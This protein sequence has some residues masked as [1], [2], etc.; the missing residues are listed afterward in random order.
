MR[1]SRSSHRLGRLTAAVCVS[2]ASLALLTNSLHAQGRAREKRI[3]TDE[4]F[5]SSVLP[6][7]QKYCIECH[8][9][10]EA[11]GDVSF[12]DF[13]RAE[14]V[15]E[16]RGTWE[17]AFKHLGVDGMP[18]KD[19]DERPTP[20]ERRKLVEWLELKLYHVDPDLVDD[21]GRVTIQ[22]LNRA[23]YNNTVRD[24][25]GVDIQAAKDFPADDVGYGFSNIGD[26]LS[27]PPLLL[28]KYVAAAEKI[29]TAAISTD[30][31]EARRRILLARPSEKKTAQQAARE[32]FAA[33]MP[34][35]F[36]RPVDD[37]E[38]DRVVALVKLADTRGDSFE[39]GIQAGLQAILISPHFLFRIEYDAQPN[40]PQAEHH[41]SDFE[42]AARLSYFL[43]ST[44]PDEEL[45]RLAKANKLHERAVLDKQIARMLK[46]PKAGALV[47]NFASQW[48][49]L[50]ALAE[51]TP[52]PKL[53][54][55]FSPQLRADMLRETEMFCAAIFREDRSLLDFLDADFTFLNERL[56]KHY[57][58]AGVKGEKFRRVSLAGT[59]RAGVMTHASIL[60]LTSNP[61]RTSLVKRGNWI[62]NNIM[63]LLLP[64]PPGNV[65]SLEEGAKKSGA[66]T[67]RDQ[68]K[69]HRESAAC[70]SCHETL[71]PLGFGFENFDAI[72]R[73]RDKAEGRPVESGGVLP[74]GDAFGGPLELVKVLKQRKRKFA[75]L[76]TKKMFTYALG[77]GLELPDSVA[78]DDVVWNL[79]N[80]DY[81]FSVLVRGI[82]HSRP[83]LMRRGDET[84]KQTGSAK[85]TK[86]AKKDEGAKK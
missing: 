41:L 65:P 68:L 81:R 82:V 57:S 7:V 11:E 77:R 23:E 13:R 33:L 60:T 30:S 45:F 73:W 50:G 84:A 38:V 56:A 64:E 24:L 79:E 18:P 27:L 36:R 47:K 8:G 43:W 15:L 54:P 51:V 69:L 34:R 53:F 61:D 29:A 40:N 42:L 49:N 70:A 59:K 55:S 14:Q 74:P 25:L 17:K 20:A 52:D 32:I 6:V 39:R 80:N 22:R 63:G 46:S 37:A 1:N 35:A 16:N 12:V 76:L 31:P 28:E 3:A 2:L 71:D 66:T 83:F 4:A 78:V 75:E 67:L 72:G 86:A 62:V 58:I 9:E 21:V 85:K 19:H 26:V 10:D 44:M 48:L 5:K